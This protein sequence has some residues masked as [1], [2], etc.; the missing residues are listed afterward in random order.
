LLRSL[1]ARIWPRIEQ[2]LNSPLVARLAGF[3][4]CIAPKAQSQL[5]RRFARRVESAPY[6]IVFFIN[7]LTTYNGFP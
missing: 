7:D 5:S 3:F 2:D 6:K 1:K 4:L